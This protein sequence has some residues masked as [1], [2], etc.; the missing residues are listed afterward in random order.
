MNFTSGDRYDGE[1]FEGLRH[2]QGTYTRSNGDNYVGQFEKDKYHGKGKMTWKTM[3]NNQ[4]AYYD[5][6]WRENKRHGHGIEVDCNGDVY[7]GQFFND[8][9]EGGGS[10]TYKI[11]WSYNGQWAKNLKHGTGSIISARGEEGKAEFANDSLVS[12]IYTNGAIYA[13]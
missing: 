2:G 6:Q 4:V 3:P 11:G 12:V 9:R 13:G 1:W 8:A 5:G 10:I 7:Q